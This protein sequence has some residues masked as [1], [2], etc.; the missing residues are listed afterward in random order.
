M[1]RSSLKVWCLRC[2]TLRRIWKFENRGEKASSVPRE[3]GKSDEVDSGD[4]D[5]LLAL[6]PDGSASVSKT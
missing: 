6:L 2:E 5:D 3:K 4:S 1:C